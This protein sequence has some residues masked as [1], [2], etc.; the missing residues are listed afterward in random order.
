MHDQS[1]GDEVDRVVAGWGRERPELPVAPIE[2]IMRLNRVRARFDEE[3]AGVFARFDL[4]PADFAV[5]AVLRRQGAPFTCPQ[6]TLMARLA[7]TSGTV[8]VR[9]ARLEKKG[10]VERRPG[11]DRRGVLVT[12]TER[13]ARLFDE[14]APEHLANE[15]VLLSSLTDEERGRLATLLR[16]LLVAFEHDQV[17]LPIG[18]TV[19]PAQAAR[20]A[21]QSVGLSDRAGLLV[22]RVAPASPAGAA[23]IQPGDLLVGLAGRPL[24]S[25]VD[26]AEAFESPREPV[27]LQVLRG[28]TERSLTV[29]EFLE[30][31]D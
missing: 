10:I 28:E 6:S 15:D 30:F 13:G 20:R 5:I 22:H 9:L 4:S 26:L 18:L 31:K 17:D 27:H 7:L 11:D 1:V 21:R 16:K 19:L 24:R 29:D 12:L 8:S 25:V 14:V 23:G 3:L 2:I